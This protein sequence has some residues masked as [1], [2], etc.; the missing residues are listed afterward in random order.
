MFNGTTGKNTNG[1]LT[2]LQGVKTDEQI[3]ERKPV[4]PE[5]W[6]KL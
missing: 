3:K 2:R 4:L 5:I 1:C 6:V